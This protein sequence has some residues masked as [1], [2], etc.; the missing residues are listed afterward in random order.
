MARG[1]WKV[2]LF[3]C[4]PHEC[5]HYLAARLLGL[6]TCLEPGK[7]R[8]RNKSRWK[9]LLATLAPTLVGIGGLLLASLWYVH[10]TTPLWR[11]AVFLAILTAIVWL[12]ACA[13]DVRDAWRLLRKN[14]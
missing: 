4:W 3:A 6:E 2:A 7:T 9:N 13:Y 5:C 11:L 8:I 14:T 10:M 1:V 12:L